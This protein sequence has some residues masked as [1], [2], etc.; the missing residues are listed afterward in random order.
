MLDD[1]E[2]DKVDDQRCER[3]DESDESDER[4]QDEAEVIGAERYEEREKRNA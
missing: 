3:C 1:P 4:S 2:Q